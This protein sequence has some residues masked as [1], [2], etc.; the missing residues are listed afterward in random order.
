MESCVTLSSVMASKVLLNYAIFLDRIFQ[1]HSKEPKI[2]QILCRIASLK[3]LKH[4]LI[5]MKPR[6]PRLWLSL[7]PR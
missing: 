2:A 5:L 4:S 3:L 7:T 1:G 6:G